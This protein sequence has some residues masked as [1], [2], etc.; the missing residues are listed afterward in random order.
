[1]IE[2]VIPVLKASIPG[3]RPH[4]LRAARW[5]KATH[6]EGDHGDNPGCCGRHITL[7]T[8]PINS[9]DPNANGLGF[10]HPIQQL[11][12]DVGVTT[13]EELEEITMGETLE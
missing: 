13:G 12:E 2:E 11:K 4:D 10:F 5:C 8:Q 1:M 9:P 7:E 6:V 3:H